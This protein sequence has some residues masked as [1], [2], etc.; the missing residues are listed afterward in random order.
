MNILLSLVAYQHR[1]V[2]LFLYILSLDEANGDLFPQFLLKINSKCSFYLACLV[3]DILKN[4][5]YKNST[6]NMTDYFALGPV[7]MHVCINFGANF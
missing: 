4:K 1:T 3:V 7:T 6:D 2:V 5:P